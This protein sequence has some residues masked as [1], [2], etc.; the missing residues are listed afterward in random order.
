MIQKTATVC[1]LAE[2]RQSLP[3]LVDYFENQDYKDGVI[4]VFVG[5]IPENDVPEILKL[6][7]NSFPKMKVIGFSVAQQALLLQMDSA[8]VISFTA[9]NMS[10]AEPF[11]KE[12]DTNNQFFVEDCLN[13]AKEL[14]EHLKTLK[15]VKAIEIYFS[16]LKSSAAKFLEVLTEG[17]E[18]IPVFGAIAAGNIA[19]EV[20]NF[21]T[22][23]NED[24]FV[25]S[26]E[27]FNL[28]ISG[29]I[30]SGEELY[31]YE[32]YL[33]GWE[34]LGRYM[35]ISAQAITDKGTTVISSIDG[36]RPVDVFKKY[37]GVETN[38]YF[39][40]NLGEFPIV[41]ERN[42]LLIGRTLSGLGA[43]G[44]VYL[45]GDVL[46]DEKI[47]L[48]YAEAKELLNDTRKAANR[49]EA[50]RAERLTL[51]IC[52]NRFNFLQD[53]YMME[54][55]Y[56]SE[57]REEKPNVIIGMGEIF[58][59]GGK[60]GVLNSALVAVGMREGLKSEEAIP[61]LTTRQTHSYDEIIPLSERLSHFLKAM[62]K[63]LE[64]SAQDAEAA[65][66]AK[67]EFLSNMSH[68]IRTPLNAM[69]GLDEMIL[70]EF[71]DPQLQ[72][73]AHDIKSAGNTLISIINDIL[74]FSKIEAGKMDIINV[75]YDFSSV[76]NDIIHMAMPKVESKGL[77]FIPEMDKNM[78]SVINGDEI[79]IKQII[80]NLLSNAIKY[81][82]KGTVTLSVFSTKTSENT[83]EFLVSVK[84][85]GIGIKEDEINKL[86]DA[87]Q[88]VD[89]EKNRAIQGTGLGLNI[90]KKLLNLMGSE[91]KVK[92]EYG[93][94]SEFYFIISQNVVKWDPVGD[95]MESYKR[96]L[97]NK[98]AYKEKFVAP[99]AEVLVV[100]DT[101]LNISVFKGLLKKTL[102]NIDEAESGKQSLEMTR[103]KKYD[104]IFLDYRMPQMDG[105][106][107]LQ[108][109]QKEKDNPNKDVPVICL[110]ANAI[111]GVREQYI[112]A[113]F[114][115]Y[116][117]KPI[118]SDKLEAMMISYL[119][120]DKV[121]TE[122]SNTTNED[123]ENTTIFPDWLYKAKNIDRYE[124]LKNC[125]SIDIYMD[126]VKSFTNSYAE[127]NQLINRFYNDK[128]ISDYTVKVHALKSS[129]RF[130]GAIRLAKLAESLEIA[131]DNKDLEA[132]KKDTE[133]LLSLYK[134]VFD[135]LKPVMEISN[136][137]VLPAIEKRQF[138]DALS[139]LKELSFSFDY[140]GIKY[141]LDSLNEYKIPDKDRILLTEIEGALRHAD[142]EKIKGILEEF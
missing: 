109:L 98:E 70:R 128:N 23:G 12:I 76:L 15:N 1:D 31:V 5:N 50:F 116:L 114:T 48:S 86:F 40:Q 126:A 11:Y 67:S 36:M 3:E 13:Y 10:K 35:D 46:E 96:A 59:H 37:L 63:E 28:G 140:D 60:G 121:S 113:G 142:W 32:E 134:N 141:I 57:G 110:T 92:S 136:E 69:L 42:G 34:P 95:Y 2:L 49:M 7:N 108:I 24:S 27:D 102:V 58:M 47:R 64:E 30:F 74:D 100:D 33:F 87:F 56:Y 20:K 103:K 101:P 6:I 65:N 39:I 106:E 16:Y 43:K 118:M 8:I 84:D 129:A 61:V 45:K 120:Q 54:I 80:T 133:K 138:T 119:P 78:P 26:G 66:R 112:K 68:E 111:S 29:M 17:L 125:G 137:K 99:D 25:I 4:E 132:I 72:E 117:T 130:I 21:I 55:N 131:G 51:I 93:K 105:I 90:T 107:T 85:T 115:D 123:N 82:E 9:L 19:G 127:N 62:T 91:L 83:A 135:D 79:R 124:G 88:R 73:Y 75:D 139:T 52:G 94:G 41:L 122:K 44:E 53:D 22:M 77:T 14:N 38:D 104:L 71:D 81:T 18:N 97:F 89:E